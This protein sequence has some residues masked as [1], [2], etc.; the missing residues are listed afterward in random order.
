MKGGGDR[1]VSSPTTRRETDMAIDVKANVDRFTVRMLGF[2]ENKMQVIKA[3]R[4][5]TGLGLKEAKDFVEA[6]TPDEP[7]LVIPQAG[8]GEL[9]TPLLTVEQA[10]N[11]FAKLLVAGANVQLGKV[12][13][14]TGAEIQEVGD[15]LP[16]K[17]TEIKHVEVFPSYAYLVE[18]EVE[19]ASIVPY[20]DRNA[21]GDPRVETVFVP[22]TWTVVGV[23][24]SE[25]VARRLVA[26]E[27]SGDCAWGG[28]ET[29]P[30]MRIRR[31]N[32]TV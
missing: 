25:E 27:G 21:Q 23:A 29:F 20:L 17:F 8:F 7:A 9:P 24:Y 1:N 11:A 2:G 16:I 5:I 4:D 13:P 22:E 14:N 28:S 6:A 10:H 18:K 12:D 32:A 3:L 31:I 15:F 30:R 26:N 19:P